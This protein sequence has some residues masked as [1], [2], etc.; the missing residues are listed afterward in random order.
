MTSKVKKYFSET[1]FDTILGFFSISIRMVKDLNQLGHKSH[2]VLGTCFSTLGHIEILSE[3][4]WVSI[5]MLS[6]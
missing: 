1:N 4:S 3:S 6:K 5:P 2:G